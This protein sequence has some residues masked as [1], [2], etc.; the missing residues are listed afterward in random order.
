MTNRQDIYYWKCDRPSAFFALK[1]QHEAM[2]VKEVQALLLPRLIRYFGIDLVQLVPATGQGNHLT[3]LASAE[4]VAIF[5]RLENGPEGDDF[6]EIE[7]HVLREIRALGIPVPAVL[8]VDATRAEVPFAYQILEYLKYPDLNALFKLGKLNITLIARAVGENVA[9][10]QS[11]QPS[12]FGPFDPEKLRSENALV[13]L[14][15]TYRDYF[16][17]NWEKH[18]DFLVLRKFLSQAESDKIQKLVFDHQHYLDIAQGCLVHKDLALWNMLGEA[19]EIKAFIDWDDTISGD[20]TD[21]LSLLA[22]FHSGE[23]VRAALDGYESVAPLPE[24]F[25]PRFWLHLLRNMIV[26]AVIRVGADY[27]EKESDFF[28]IGTGSSGATLRD[29]TKQRI[30]LAC[31]GLENKKQI[32]DL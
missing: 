7:A 6:M 11:V 22:C 30:W 12:G 23:V 32:R 20:A 8:E 3:F 5:V 1:D 4:G 15:K 9:R 13:G 19:E 21:D 27:F 26:K 14:H 31:K 25:L 2:D 29:F 16:L 18:L 28:L 17:L 10:W 24:D